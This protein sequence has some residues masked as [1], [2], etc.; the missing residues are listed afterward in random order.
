[1]AK[2][3][4]DFTPIMFLVAMTVG[5]V[6]LKMLTQQGGFKN[7]FGGLDKL[8]GDLFTGL[9]TTTTQAA[10]PTTP[11]PSTPAPSTPA[12][13]TPAPA[14][15]AGGGCDCSCMPMDSDPTRQKIETAAGEDCANHAYPG[16]VAECETLL[17]TVCASRGG[18]GGGGTTTPAPAAEDGGEEGGGDGEEEEAGGD[19]EESG[20]LARVFRARRRRVY[21]MDE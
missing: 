17:A 4:I 13:S 6:L 19:E 5:V 15:A 11:A 8:I 2:G 12:P 14:P 10:P 7:I 1:M 3:G 16:S 9:G 21:G 20:N 18:G